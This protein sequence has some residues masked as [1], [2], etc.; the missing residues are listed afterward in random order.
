MV[1][2]FPKRPLAP[3]ARNGMALSALMTVP[4]R[5]TGWE[6]HVLPTPPCPRQQPLAP[7]ARNGQVLSALTTAPLRCTGWELH[8]LPTPP[9]PRQQPLA[10]PL[11]CTG[12]ELHV[13]PTPPCPL[14]QLL[15]EHP[16]TGTDQRACMFRPTE[17]GS[18]NNSNCNRK[19]L[20][21]FAV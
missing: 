4:L 2:K 1:S 20:I 14:R 8:V 19:L 18:G 9:C 17:R 16:R 10:P 3:V 5:C 13:S 15:V 12:T 11:T 7:L 6:L 21:L